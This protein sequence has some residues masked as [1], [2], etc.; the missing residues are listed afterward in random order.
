MWLSLK[1]GFN[2]S[3][4][5]SVLLGLKSE[6]KYFNLGSGTQPPGHQPC[7]CV[8]CFLTTVVSS[9]AKTSQHPSA[10][11][12]VLFNVCGF[13][14]YDFCLCYS[15]AVTSIFQLVSLHAAINGRDPFPKWKT[16][17]S[18]FEWE[19]LLF[20][21]SIRTWCESKWPSASDCHYA[22]L[23]PI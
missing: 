19:P 11:T 14:A 2:N 8:F 6:R 20:F 23:S 3:E 9:A 10:W 1:Y 21:P 15:A 7:A 18:I 5:W 12:S 13:L 16:L 17:S 4:R 22:P